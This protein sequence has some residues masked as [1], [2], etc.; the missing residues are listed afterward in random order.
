MTDDQAQACIAKACEDLGLSLERRR[1]ILDLSL[2]ARRER[3]NKACEV[4][5]APASTAEGFYSMLADGPFSDDPRM[6]EP[7][8][9]TA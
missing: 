1:E 2:S 4:L 9:G 7:P 5:R 8:A 3:V 6:M